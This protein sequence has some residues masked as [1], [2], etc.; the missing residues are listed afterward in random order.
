MKFDNDRDRAPSDE[1]SDEIRVRKLGLRVHGLVVKDGEFR[2]G[3]RVWEREGDGRRA[4]GKYGS[5]QGIRWTIEVANAKELK[6]WLW[7]VGFEA[8][9]VGEWGLLSRRRW[10]ECNARERTLKWWDNREGASGPPQGNRV[11]LIKSIRQ[12]PKSAK[13]LIITSSLNKAYYITPVDAGISRKCMCALNE[14][15]LEGFKVKARSLKLT[16]WLSDEKSKW[17]PGEIS[18]V[19]SD[20]TFDIRFNNGETGGYVETGLKAECVKPAES[21]EEWLLCD[22]DVAKRIDNAIEEVR[23]DE[24]IRIEQKYDKLIVTN[25]AS[26][27][28]S[29]SCRQAL[30]LPTENDA[31]M[32]KLV[33]DK[34][35]TDQQA[36]DLASLTTRLG[37]PQLAE[38]PWLVRFDGDRVTTDMP[39]H[40][41][42]SAPLIRFSERQ[43]LRVL[44]EGEWRWCEVIKGPAPDAVDSTHELR[45]TMEKKAKQGDGEQ[46][47][48]ELL[49]GAK[50]MRLDLHPLNHA[51]ALLNSAEMKREEQALKV[52]LTD[53]HGKVHDIFSGEQLDSESQLT[54]LKY[55]ENVR[56]GEQVDTDTAEY[57]AARKKSQQRA[58]EQGDDQLAKGVDTIE[59]LDKICAVRDREHACW[60]SS[61]G[62]LMLGPAAIG[63]STQLKRFTLLA[64]KR[65]MVPVLMLVIELVNILRTSKDGKLSNVIER[66]LESQHGRDSMRYRL[67]M[68]AVHERRC[69]FLVDGVDEAGDDKDEIERVIVDE[70]L[71]EGHK[72]IVTSRHSGFKMQSFIKRCQ[73]VELLPMS[74]A[75]QEEMV[76]ARLGGKG[77]TVVQEFMRV[78]RDREDYTEIANIPMM[79]SMLIA[80]FKARGNTFPKNRSES[81]KKAK[82][83][84]E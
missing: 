19:N 13:G 77:E 12:N 27:A 60:P 20:G 26:D 52:Q 62:I 36:T 10:C 34:D 59:I 58:E 44:V 5:M 61:S 41:I 23:Q 37:E 33:W 70:L 84:N 55:R 53:K 11:V 4:T 57:Q 78:L 48:Q 69:L 75:Q 25:L 35:E 15:P 71:D 45:V 32:R 2:T 82:E 67:L 68:Q 74:R 56:Y 24:E 30:V 17:L 65:D 21:F 66:Y 83:K 80:V 16:K 31:R 43:R 18:K 40:T 79:L 1:I 14:V 76:K 51:I 3:Q 73:I 29:L 54:L 39:K 38:Q 47:E 7:E 22:Q 28:T 8:D 46:E 42:A 64:L 50:I 6:T 9:K 49:A 63:K 81:G 72:M